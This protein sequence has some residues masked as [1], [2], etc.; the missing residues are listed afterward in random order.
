MRIIISLLAAIALL[1]AGL[2][3][4]FSGSGRDGNASFP[5]TEA[6]PLAASAGAKLYPPEAMPSDTPGGSL[7]VSY[8]LSLALGMPTT[9][10][11]VWGGQQSR[12]A[13]QGED[14]YVL[15][16]IANA[17]PDGEE[18]FAL[19]RYSGARDEWTY[20]Y[21][22]RS[23][24]IPGLHAA[25]NG[26]IYAA[27]VH[28]RGLG[29]LE[30][31]PLTDK[32]TMHDPGVFWPAAH[33]RDHWAY[34][35][36]GI[37]A[38]RYIWFLGCGNIEGKRGRPGGFAIYKYDTET[39]SFDM[40][41]E[42]RHLTEFRHCYNYVLDDK[43]GG[44]VIAG[45]RAIFWDVSEWEQA[46]G[47]MDAIWDEVNYWTFK[48]NSLSDIRRVDKAMQGESCPMPNAPINYAGDAFLDSNGCLHIL[49]TL[50]SAHIGGRTQL[51]HAVY[52]DGAEVKKEKLLD[53]QHSVR[54]IED[55]T[56]QLYMI[57][58]PYNSH[59]ISLFTVDAQHELTL[60][61]EIE[62]AGND[63]IGLAYAGMAVTAP[64]TGSTPAD[65]VDVIY[66][67]ID[68]TNWIYFRLQ[69]R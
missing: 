63:S 9:E 58:L 20:F 65:F 37:T 64:R 15:F 36:T 17:L 2:S 7:A 49:Y 28:A 13:R 56:G 34:M 48:N 50:T 30:Y 38:G 59:T 27:Y 6:P 41:V 32:I 4:F 10:H 18:A 39:R 66:P 67:N 45:E 47:T 57:N 53:G 42:P 55:A 22:L 52:E 3:A 31:D 54:L 51:W 61:R 24:E 1:L 12:I 25:A 43:D 40:T 26:N 5:E 8:N 11:G 60:L 46:P 69:L 29:V 23:Y 68:R 14:L 21:T 44:I 16:G 35:S 33:A 62:I 19:Y